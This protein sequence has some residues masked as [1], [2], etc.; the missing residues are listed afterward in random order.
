[1]PTPGGSDAADRAPAEQQVIYRVA[2]AEPGQSLAALALMPE[3]LNSPVLPAHFWVAHL[4][5]STSMV[6]GAAAFVPLIHHAI[7]P[8]YRCTAQVLPGWRR[9][10]VGRALMDGLRQEAQRWDL[11]Y[12]HAWND[13][14]DGGTEA[15]FLQACGFGMGHT[16][17]HFVGRASRALARMQP[18]VDRLQTR[19]RVPAEFA[20][21]PLQDVPLQAVAALHQREFGGSIQGAV[22]QI[23]TALKMPLI[24]QLS[25]GLWDGQQLAG[26]LLAGTGAATDST[27]PH[28]DTIAVQYWASA[29]GQ[30]HGWAAAVLLH[31]F[32][33]RAVACGYDDVRFHCND[34]TRATLNIARAIGSRELAPTRGWVLDLQGT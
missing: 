22:A 33:Q 14:I 26:Y 5:E 9:Q 30:R 12:L 34:Q 27:A 20:L 23:E 28:C 32:L 24:S 31:D 15:R 1:M 6:V 3:L 11:R 8:G 25:K 2:R 21:Q 19:G 7:W 10:G 4:R 29:P 16:L 17:Q 13:V 18:L